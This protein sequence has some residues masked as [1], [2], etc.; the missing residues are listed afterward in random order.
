M[1]VGT[2]NNVI[3]DMKVADDYKV[4]QVVEE[5]K[6][7][8]RKV[9]QHEMAHKIAGGPY[10]GPP[11]FKFVRGPDGRLYAVAGEV[12]IDTS[13]EKDPED[14]IRK[15]EQVIRAAL[16]P[17]DPS[18]QDRKVAAEAAQ[19]LMKARVQLIKEK[20]EKQQGGNI[21]ITV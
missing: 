6:T 7:I 19:K 15:M 17:A 5:L 2:I 12:K 20:Q 8:D 4:R 11:Q 3:Q 21:D 9:R 13:E 16:A 14:T 1:D 10:A 18:P